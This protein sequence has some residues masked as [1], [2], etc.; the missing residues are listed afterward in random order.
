MKQDLQKSLHYL[1]ESLR[2]IKALVAWERLKRCEMQAGHISMFQMYDS[3]VE[4]L[5]NEYSLLITAL[6][7]VRSVLNAR[8]SVI[9]K[10]ARDGIGR[11]LTEIE[12]QLYRLRL[13]RRFGGPIA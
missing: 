13:Y 10:T 5:R 7:N 11:Q 6:L 12:W 4:D 8:S 3:T 2:R 1:H 9:S